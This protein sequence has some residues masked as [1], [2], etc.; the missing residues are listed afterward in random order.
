MLLPLL[1]LIVTAIFIRNAA[2]ECPS[3][4][5][6]LIAVDIAVEGPETDA[7]KV[8]RRGSKGVDDEWTMK[9]QQQAL[10]ILQTAGDDSSLILT[11]RGYK[12]G[13]V[14][15]QVNQDRAMLVR[16]L[17]IFAEEKT[18]GFFSQLLGVFDGHGVG[19]EKT[20]Q[21]ALE[22]F[23]KLLAEKLATIAGDDPA[24]LPFQQDAI[25]AAMTDVFLEVDQTDPTKGNAGCTAS[26]VLQLGPKLYI[27]NAGDSLSFVGV[28]YGQNSV[29][30]GDG[31]TPPQQ[32]KVQ[33]VYKTREDK[34][35]LP[36]ER[37]RI[38]AAGGYV[39]IPSNSE[40]DV[41]RAYHIDQEGRMLWGLAMSRSLGD[42]SVQGV[43]AEPIVDVLDVRDIVQVAL[44][45]HEEAC[46]ASVDAS[47]EN[48][49]DKE[50]YCEALNPIN[51]HIFCVSATDGMMDELPP[52]FIGSVL[53]PAFFDPNGLHPLT[54]AE[55]LILESAKGWNKLYNGG[56]R[57]D[58]AIAAATVL[59]DDSVLSHRQSNR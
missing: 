20:S 36:D 59:S 48:D 32:V 27:A 38:V 56:Y 39:N 55:R 8:L 45:T 33:I 7:L 53:A 10:S 58:I 25:K 11:L 17:R 30:E 51:L 29:G 47:M 14:D 9:Q 42:W 19:G 16:P 28:Y 54:A 5:C 35:D 34:P 46:L 15:G 3:Y 13:N 22:R 40:V 2:S 57:D 18:H 50:K 49:N 23:P 44:A 12:G 31:K 21:H 52:D 1:T 24:K 26:V 37:A 41:P 6:P 43:I 4:G